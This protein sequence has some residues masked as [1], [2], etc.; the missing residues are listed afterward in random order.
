VRRR[1]GRPAHRGL[2]GVGEDM[3]APPAAQRIDDALLTA[4]EVEAQPSHAVVALRRLK[5]A[6][7][8]KGVPCHARARREVRRCSRRSVVK[9]TSIKHHHLASPRRRTAII[10]SL[11]RGSAPGC[12]Q[13]RRQISAAPQ[14]RSEA[15]QRAAKYFSPDGVCAKTCRKT[16]SRGIAIHFVIFSPPR[17]RFS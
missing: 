10:Q 2:L 3:R 1:D 15:N 17:R 16:R 12:R 7:C 5:M 9:S 6:G 13:A 14:R 8:V 4:E 11:S